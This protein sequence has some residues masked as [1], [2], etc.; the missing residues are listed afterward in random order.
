MQLIPA[1]TPSKASERPSVTT[2]NP[3]GEPFQNATPPGLAHFYSDPNFQ[4]FP[5]I[6][7]NQFKPIQT[8]F[9][10]FPISS[11]QKAVPS[12]T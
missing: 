2:E 7:S 4:S 11:P 12:S 10:L 9:F 8:T 5:D 6:N 1:K 3:E